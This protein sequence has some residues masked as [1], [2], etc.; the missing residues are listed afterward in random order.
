M[1]DQSR[2]SFTPNISFKLCRT[3]QMIVQS[4]TNLS[5]FVVVSQE[6]GQILRL[7]DGRRLRHFS[8][9]LGGS[10]QRKETDLEEQIFRLW[11]TNPQRKHEK[12]ELNSVLNTET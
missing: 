9:E 2:S 4:M 3:D 12:S 5:D 7:L 1:N 8:E 10:G 11:G 6:H